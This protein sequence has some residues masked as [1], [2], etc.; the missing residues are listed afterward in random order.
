MR[1]FLVVLHAPGFEREAD[2][3]EGTEPAY[4][5]KFITQPAIEAFNVT[6]LHRA[7]S[8]TSF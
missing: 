4:I 1:S 7:I 2:L 8:S 6:V 5:E 3:V